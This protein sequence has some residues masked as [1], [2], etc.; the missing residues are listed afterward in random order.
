MKSKNCS[1]N[2]IN[3]LIQ[4]MILQCATC[5]ITI[6]SEINR[7]HDLSLL[8]EGNGKDHVPKGFYCLATEDDYVNEEDDEFILNL[9]N[10][11]NTQI[12][13]DRRIG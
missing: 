8:F 13:N 6:S 9:D 2:I 1:L 7:L 11:I 5:N 12:R 4:T 3:I 10:V